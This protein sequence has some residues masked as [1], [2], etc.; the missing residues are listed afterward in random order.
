[1]GK[2]KRK[3]EPVCASGHHYVLLDCPDC[4]NMEMG[5]GEEKHEAV[6]HPTHYQSGKYEVIDII[7]EFQL[8]FALGNV[9]KYVLRAARKG[10][11]EKDLKKALWYLKRELGLPTDE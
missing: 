9:I 1:M 7:E 4:Y 10:E 3:Q 2:K 11:A 5:L 6:H 8:N